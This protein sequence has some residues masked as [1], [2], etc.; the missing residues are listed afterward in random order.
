MKFA[1]VGG[2]GVQNTRGRGEESV[3]VVVAG[4]GSST[5]PR[6]ACANT[7]W[8]ATHIGGYPRGPY[9]SSGVMMTVEIWFLLIVGNTFSQP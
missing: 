4:S 2:D 7:S 9:A 5:H 6:A 3:L 1:F 8:D